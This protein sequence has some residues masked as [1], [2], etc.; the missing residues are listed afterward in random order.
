MVKKVQNVNIFAHSVNTHTNE[1]ILIR[2]NMRL[3]GKK[4]ALF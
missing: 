4:N 3:D 2:Y 1:K